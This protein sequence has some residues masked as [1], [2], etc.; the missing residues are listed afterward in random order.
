MT[1]SFRYVAR[2]LGRR[3]TR[4]LLGALGIF[5]TLS[6]LTAIQIGIDSISVSYTDLVALQA[7][8]A[9]LII[10]AEGS[11]WLQPKPFAPAEVESKLK[12]NSR[13]RGV[14]PRL[15]GI[16]QVGRGDTEHHAVL[17]GLNSARERELDISG[18]SP[19]P[20]LL[21][22]TCAVSRSLAG[23]L[24][25]DKETELSIRSSTTGETSAM[26]LAAVIDRQLILP[27]EVKD[28]IVV[29]E[30]AARSLLAEPERVHTLAGAFR[31]SRASYD[32]RD[33]HA[34]MLRLKE[35]GETIA[36]DLGM[37]YDVRL[38]KAAAIA[39]FQHFTSP[40]RAVFGVF[41][42]LALTVTGLLIYSIISVAV[43]ERIR[44]YGVLRTLGAKRRDIFGL[45]LGESVFL[46]ALGV[47]PGVLAGMLVARGIL[48][49]VGLI[50][51]AEGGAITLVVSPATLWLTLLAG[52]VLSIGSA[53]I[54]AVKASRWHIVDAL[55]PLRRGQIRHETRPEGAASRPLLLGGLAL[56]ALSVVVLFILPT[57]FLSGNPS[58]IG[59][60]VL[61]LLLAT[62][63]GFTLVAV[64]VLPL[65]EWCVM[66]AVGWAFGP[67]AEL[68]RRN[69]VRHR[70]RNTTTALMFILSISLV[71]FVASLVVLASRTAMDMVEHFNGA[72]FRLQSEFA[73]GEDPK[74]NLARI[75]G[76]EQVAE[77]RFLRGRTEQGV[78]YDVVLSDLVGMKQLWIVPFGVD[79]NIGKV[80]Y[81]DRI[82]FAEGGPAAF[83]KLAAY[84][85]PV[86]TEETGPN[87]A[88]PLI[89]SLSAAEYLDARAGDTV[90]LSFRLGAERRDGRF[91]VEAVCGAM[92]GFDNFRSR[93]A[94]AV[95]S[96]IM[97]PLASFK[98]MT[99]TA[100]AETF[101]VRYFL[102][103]APGEEI[104]QT[105][106]KRIREES[107]LR[108]RFG[109][110]SSLEQKRTAK[111]LY[112]VTQVFFG[113]VLT[114]AVLISV[115]AL[116]A[117]MA[118]AAIERRWEIGVLKAL[119]L[120]RSHLFR[121]FL[122]EAT[123]LTLSA[124]IAGGLIGFTLAYLFALQAGMLMEIP[125]VFTMPY[126]TFLATFAISVMAGA[127]AAHLPTRHLLRKPAAEILRVEV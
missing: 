86:K 48:G 73:S 2:N 68:A 43:E 46:C 115:F 40:L 88:P 8:K 59:T 90:K 45:I 81:T 100:P 116:I 126:V 94:N 3:R 101:L 17:I 119:G 92:P 38:P 76:I 55:D 33:L 30:D 83:A 111:L 41:A 64:G 22:G 82:Q 29:N 6:L 71:I 110:K 93:V 113:M 65:I 109:V 85:V 23:R 5:L 10:T 89:L 77:A 123:V 99:Q 39:T 56:S 60:V 7:G 12:G 78:A 51:H 95:G 4:T 47:I 120:R 66:A 102:K 74:S 121:M 114:V 67:S 118:T 127:L 98:Q 103:A 14:S 58:L 52:A 104:Q 9:D 80:L 97:M 15:M 24:K 108:Y 19:D 70:R 112:W 105:V 13:L 53:V 87:A 37:N 57:A 25:A 28:F 63:L 124:G 125:I 31:D 21:K 79:A 18:L 107:D 106:A 42:V 61:G 69:L 72:D 91:R 16:V 75:E 34:S 49:L 26:R 27:Q 84:Q 117:S 50:M 20:I 11:H 62:L 1:A 54:P 32:A 44:E 122:G 36:A 35:V 96:G